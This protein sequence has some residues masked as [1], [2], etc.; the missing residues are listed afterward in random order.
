MASSVS[1]ATSAVATATP[2]DVICMTDGSYGAMTL[3][4]N[5]NVTLRAQHPGMATIGTTTVSGH[6]L[7]LARF[8][9]DGEVQWGPGT[10]ETT[11]EHNRISGGY[12]G[13]DACMS[14]T[15]TCN[16]DAIIGNQFIGPFGADGIRANRYHDANGDGI[17]L[18]VEG[19]EF[20]GIRE[21]GEHSDCMQTVWAGDHLVYRK[22]YLHDNRCQGL[23]IK[24]QDHSIEGIRAEDNLLLR[25]RQPCGRPL[26]SCGQPYIFQ[27]N[28]PYSHFVMRRN[29]IWGDGLDSIATFR[30]SSGD[31]ATIEDNVVYRFWTDINLTGATMNR[32][33]RCKLEVAPG[34]AWPSSRPGEVTAC[35]LAFPHP[36]LDDYRLGDG[37]GVDWAPAEEHY[38][39]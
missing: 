12:F 34:G 39:P 32:N 1:A 35:E 15:T 10:S 22:N 14:T 6:G 26:T 20:T 31:Q 5:A 25:N 29:T 11:V 18:L 16:D 28:G 4:P 24:D 38:G 2:G 27:V 9:I 17:G 7:T 37:R 3:E 21:N 8:Q 33:T 30:G 13:V 19:N 23:F 36:G